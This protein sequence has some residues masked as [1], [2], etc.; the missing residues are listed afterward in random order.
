MRWVERLQAL[1][2]RRMHTGS[3][4]K[5]R[6]K[7]PLGRLKRRWEDNIKM[8]LRETGFGGMDLIPL[9]WDRE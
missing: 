5:A 1:E 7:R 3:G 4:G 2:R 9:A 6:G 8:N